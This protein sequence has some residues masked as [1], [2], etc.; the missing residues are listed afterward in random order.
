MDTSQS[1]IDALV[2]RFFAAFDNRQGSVPTTEKFEA[3][4]GPSGFVV[5]H[6]GG[7]PQVS[8]PRAFVEPRVAL[9]SSGSLVDFHEWETG[10]QTEIIG[11]LAVRRSRYAKQG[12]HDSKPYAGT[13]TKFFQLA[14]L[15]QGWRIMSVAWIDD[16]AL[17]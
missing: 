14:R 6:A 13:G 1:E 3:L 16:P 2:A 5:T 4:F 9:L 17:G 12:L 10:S 15:Q 7:D 11:T 8:T